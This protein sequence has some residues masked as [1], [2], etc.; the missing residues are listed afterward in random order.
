MV[1]T[2]KPKVNLFVEFSSYSKASSCALFFSKLLIL[3]FKNR[4]EI[5]IMILS[6]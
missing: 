4:E 1:I 3:M 6:N 2:S 5:V